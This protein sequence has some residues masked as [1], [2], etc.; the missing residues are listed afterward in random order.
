MKRFHAITLL[1]TC[2]II[3][4]GLLPVIGQAQL[5]GPALSFAEGPGGTIV[6]SWSDSPS[7]F[8]LEERANLSPLTVW[9]PVPGY[10]VVLGDQLSVTV[11]PSGTSRLYRL[12]YAPPPDPAA[13]APPLSSTEPTSFLDAT[14][15]LYSGT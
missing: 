1:R 7:G 12:R 15:F 2:L 8:I 10:P 3:A 13:S 9:A 4:I 14:S 11:T 6:L 5:T